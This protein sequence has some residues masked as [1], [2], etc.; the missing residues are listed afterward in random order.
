MKNVIKFFYNL[1]ID[2]ISK[3][4]DKYYFSIKNKDYCFEQVYDDSIRNKYILNSYPRFHRI[5][6]NV[7]NDI[8]TII[9]GNMYVLLLINNDNRIIGIDD[10]VNPYCVISEID[11]VDRSINLWSSRVDYMEYEVNQ[12][13]KKNIEIRNLFSYYNGLTET[14]IQLLKCIRNRLNVF[15]VHFRVSNT[16]KMIDYYDPVNVIFDCKVRD[17]CEYLKSCFFSGIDIYNLSIG[18]LK[19]Y[20]NDEIIFF[21]ARMIYPSYF[22]DNYK[23]DSIIINDYELYLKKIYKYIRNNYD[24]PYIE[25]LM[26]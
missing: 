17:V 4:D 5:I 21:M 26:E 3:K 25:W 24:I 10:L 14:G 7:N 8:I 9:N 16:S 12:S 23:L 11:V 19:Y 13:G 2:S 1:D 20:N 15:L 22:Y 18:V 6:T